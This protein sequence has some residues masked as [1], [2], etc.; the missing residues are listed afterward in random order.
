MIAG[1]S[2]S[3]P[4]DRISLPLVS[5]PLPPDVLMPARMLNEFTY[6]PRLG[7]LE[8]VHGE[9]A[10]NDDTVQGE[11]VHR[12]VD[13]PD[14]RTVPTDSAGD[15]TT[16]LHSRSLR[17]ENPD[18]GLVAVIDLVEL[19]GQVATPVDYKKGRVPDLPEGAWEPERVQLCAQG[20]LLRAA[21][22]QSHEGIIWYAASRRRVVIPF[23]DE[24]I[25]R[26][27]SL[28]A[29]FRAVAAAGV[30]PPPLIDS[31]KCPR[32]SL[33]GICL[34]DET[35]LLR[36]SE[37]EGKSSPRML[38]TPIDSARPL[39]VVEQGAR[40]SKSGDR[41]VIERKDELLASV[42]LVDVSQLCLFG[43]IQI[44]T[45]ALSELLD[46]GIP[47]CY[48]TTGG[49]FRGIATG[50]T[51]KNI[52]L[53]I[54]QFA[55]A[56][57]PSRALALASVF[58][59]GKI[60]NARTLLRRN[61]PGDLADVLRELADAVRQ[62]EAASSLPSLL[63]IEGLAAKRYFAAFGQLL[64]TDFDFTGR[65]RRPPTDPVNCVL[66]FLYSLLTKEL[67]VA[68]LAAGLDPMLGFLHQPR[69]GRPAL[70][71]DLAEE[72]RPL[73]A[74]STCLSAFNTGELKPEHFVT[75]AG[76]CTLTPPGKRTVIAAWER[77]LN[78]EIIHP[79]FGYSVSY[80]RV[81][82]V[83]ARLLGRVLLGEIPV[84]PS[85]RTR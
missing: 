4:P 15:E 28:I 71:L 66:S 84:Y 43:N 31:P 70:A 85:F 69:Y 47:I 56:A 54:H 57:S 59:A 34:P 53:R 67:Y 42:P 18:L 29:E 5:P 20:L 30:L 35:N 81:L 16:S 17:L 73:L 6:C 14:H 77:R 72:F 38:L 37:P 22:F 41:L 60:A 11:F 68:T 7:Y 61:A 9:W 65:N 45:Q 74:D 23:T 82:A 13:V 75:R 2:L 33:V 83:Q 12:R 10:A 58:V 26:T 51:H 64:K 44:T 55:V 46:R 25:Q 40:V 48:F 52:E 63:G 3:A 62:A 39:H 50:L 21:G 1:S 8:W 19:D 76:A 27:R 36:Q 49:W 80:R 78:A 24:L 32:C 79:Y